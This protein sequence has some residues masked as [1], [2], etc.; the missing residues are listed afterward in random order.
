MGAGA[1]P[2]TRKMPITAQ[3]IG[4]RLVYSNSPTSPSGQSN[5]G[6]GGGLF[7]SAQ[8]LIGRV[9]NDPIG[10]A[11]S[12]VNIRNAFRNGGSTASGN[13]GNGGGASGSGTEANIINE[14]VRRG[15]EATTTPEQRVQAGN[16][17]GMQ[18]VA[19]YSA[20]FRAYVSEHRNILLIGAAGLGGYYL[21]TKKKGRR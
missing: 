11:A 6:S 8:N 15:L 7:G 12:V 2:A 21:L 20:A 17:A 14:L 16:A 13:T 5:S 18:L 3:R 9:L 1:G 4:G 10:T 19:D